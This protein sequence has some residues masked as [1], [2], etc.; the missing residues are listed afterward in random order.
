MKETF[1]K[2]FIRDI[3]KIDEDK[4]ELNNVTVLPNE[5]NKTEYEE[6]DIL[7]VNRTKRQAIIIENKIDANDSNHLGYR[8]GYKGQLELYYNT[9]KTGEDNN[10]KPC[11]KYKSDHIYVYYLSMRE[12]PKD[13]SES[14]GMLNYEPI[15]W[16]DNH[17]L[18]YDSHI[19][20]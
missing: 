2:I 3:L 1:L 11:L 8:E 17:I 19:R 10:R 16:G 13:F 4:F 14:V 18:A 6:I 20:E 7:I 9:I 5:N 12:L 15:S